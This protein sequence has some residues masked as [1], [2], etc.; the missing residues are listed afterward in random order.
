MTATDVAEHYV[1][2]SSGERTK[3]CAQVLVRGIT[4]FHIQCS[5]IHKKDWVD[6]SH[7]YARLS[8]RAK[9]S[10]WLRNPPLVCLT[11]Y[12]RSGLE[13]RANSSRD[14][15]QELPRAIY[16][17][18]I[19]SSGCSLLRCKSRR[20]HDHGSKTR[21][22]ACWLHLPKSDCHLTHPSYRSHERKLL[23]SVPYRH[24][25]SHPTEHH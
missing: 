22:M 16:R 20:L 12:C 1:G 10:M 8:K 6:N 5:N 23:G 4:P 11:C 25:T 7:K 13:L 24:G 9:G 3:S 18:V 2:A 21:T 19:D 17:Y 15:W 14:V